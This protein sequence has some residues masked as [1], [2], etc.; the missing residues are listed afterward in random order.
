MGR[1]EGKAVHWFRSD[2]PDISF[3]FDDSMGRVA[4]VHSV[5]GAERYM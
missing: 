3:S 4:Y 5:V 2:A 1:G